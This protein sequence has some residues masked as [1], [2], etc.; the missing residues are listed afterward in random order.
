[1]VVSTVVL[2]SMKILND[3]LIWWNQQNPLSPL[4]L[5]LPCS[6]LWI[7]FLN[8]NT[9]VILDNLLLNCVSTALSYILRA[10]I[11]SVE[12]FLSRALSFT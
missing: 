1:M 6:I 4:D 11:F 8:Q 2:F 7:E 5:F 9:T 12:P 10:C 3:Q